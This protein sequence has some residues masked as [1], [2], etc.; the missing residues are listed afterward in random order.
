M[1]LPYII[2]PIL[3]LMCFVACSPNNSKIETELET[4]AREY[5]KAMESEDHD[6]VMKTIHTGSVDYAYRNRNTER[7]FKD[8]LLQFRYIGQ[9]GEYAIA[10]FEFA[11]ER[12]SGKD[13]KNHSNDTIHVFRKEDGKWKIWRVASLRLYNK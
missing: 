9:D 1:P 13:Y 8:K 6:A 7:L 3:L 12:T 10:R 5:L 11:S 2:L 4:I